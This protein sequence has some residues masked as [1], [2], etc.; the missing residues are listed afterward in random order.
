MKLAIAI[1]IAV[2]VP[3]GWARADV[4][5]F[6][7][8]NGV[9]HLAN[10][11]LDSRYYLFKKET[12]EPAPAGE[13]ATVPDLLIGAPRRASPINLADRKHYTPLISAV[14]KEHQ[15]DPALLHAVITVESGYNP[16][17]RSP[18]GAVG[19][20]Q[21]MPDTAKRY[22]VA[23]I[24]DPRDNV[25]GGARYLRDL[26]GMFNNNLALALAAYNAGEG[27][28]TQYGNKI[29]PFAETLVYVPRVLQQY[30]ALSRP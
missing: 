8:E 6:I 17:A 7:D 4:Y 3:C 13:S 5:G 15:L 26:L 20:M 16:K 19:L 28:V 18:K 9:A 21:L 29:P 25:R 24:W 23:N 14:A 22:D 30:R 11:P 2:L 10:S 1:L 27:A 12:R